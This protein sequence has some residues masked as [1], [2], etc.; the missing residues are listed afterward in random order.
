MRCHDA[1]NAHVSS[2]DTAAPPPTRAD[3]GGEIERGLHP[4]VEHEAGRGGGAPWK[5]NSR[6]VA[7]VRTACREA[8]AARWRRKRIVFLVQ[9]DIIYVYESNFGRDNSYDKFRYNGFSFEGE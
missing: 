2:L 7:R 4:T 8:A 6:S 5:I 3:G 9:N 1:T